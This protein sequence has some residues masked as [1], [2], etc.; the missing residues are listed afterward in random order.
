MLLLLRRGAP[1]PLAEGPFQCESS[2]GSVL[3]VA[4]DAAH[5]RAVGLLKKWRE[6]ERLLGCLGSGAYYVQEEA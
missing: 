2:H 5:S 4:W 1:A 6:P 3:T